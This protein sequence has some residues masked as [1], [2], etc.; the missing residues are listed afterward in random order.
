MGIPLFTKEGLELESLGYFLK[1]TQAMSNRTR[2]KFQV[3]WLQKLRVK[4]SLAEAGVRD[5]RKVLIEGYK[6]SIVQISPWD[7]VHGL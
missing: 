7:L 4:L 2:I 5:N 3:W 6:V 1:A